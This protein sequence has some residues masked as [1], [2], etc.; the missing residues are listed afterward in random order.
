MLISLFVFCRRV[1][2]N[3]DISP[4][5]IRSIAACMGGKRT[6]RLCLHHIPSPFPAPGSFIARTSKLPHDTF[7]PPP[8]S[9]CPFPS[10]SRPLSHH[11][12]AAL[13]AL[14]TSTYITSSLLQGDWMQAPGRFGGGFILGALAPPASCWL[15]R[16]PLCPSRRRGVGVQV[17]I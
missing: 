1:W 8:H 14:T 4:L 7:I 6:D 9:L 2:M 16:S 15:L 10:S 17:D 12:D 5:I 13:T 3:D 11:M